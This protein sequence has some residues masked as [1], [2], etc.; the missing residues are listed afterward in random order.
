MHER[1]TSPTAVAVLCLIAVPLLYF[2]S[3]GPVIWVWS[4]TSPSGWAATAFDAYVF[5]AQFAYDHAPEPVP[6]A[7]NAYAEFFVAR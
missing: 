4:K 5:P 2:V 1:K 3:L 7:L 6:S